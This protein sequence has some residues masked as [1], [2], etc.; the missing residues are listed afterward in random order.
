MAVE[1]LVM[2]GQVDLWFE[3]GGELAIVDYKTDAV[4]AAE[5]HRRARI[6]RCNCG[7]TPWRWS[8]SRAAR[9]TAPGCTSCGRTRW[10]KWI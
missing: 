7:S 8:G 5:A 9:R 4:T 1:D 2:R 10:W 6:M 3:E